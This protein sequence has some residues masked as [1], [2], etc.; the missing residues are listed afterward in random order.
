MQLF[1]SIKY[2]LLS[3]LLL[4]L[5]AC[6]EGSNSGFPT[7]ECG[8]ASNLCINSFVINPD[9]AAILLGGTQTYQAIATLTDGSERDITELVTWSVDDQEKAVIVV[10]GSSVIA[11]G[12]AEGSVNILANYRGIDV[13]A[14]LSVGAIT[15]TIS[16]IEASILTGM[17][18]SYKAFAIL[19]SG[20]QIDVTEQ[21]TWTSINPIIASLTADGAN[22]EVTGL[23]SGVDAISATYNGTSIFAQLTVISTTPESLLITPA[24]TTLPAGTSQQYNAYLTTTDN[25]VIDV[26]ASSTWTVVDAS[27]ASIDVNA[28]LTA[29]TIGDTQ[30]QASIVHE[31]ITL[32][33]TAA[34]SVNNAVLSS[35]VISPENGKFP[36]G[37][38]GVYR[39]A[40]YF[41][42]GSVI[43]VTREASWQV[44]D[45]TIG[46]IVGSG[47][48]AGDSIALSPG[49]TTISASLLS[50]SDSTNVEVSTA[51]IK[52]ISLSPQNATTPVGTAINY[53]A[54][55]FYSDG[56]KRDITQ[57]GAWSSSKPSVAAINFVG[58]QSGQATA[59]VVGTT[60]ITITFDGITKSTSLTVSDAIVTKLQISPLDPSV[61]VGIEGQFTAIAYYSD[62]TTADV[63]TTTNWLVDDYT[64]AAVIPTGEF[65][66]YAKALSQGTTQL[67]AS[68]QGQSSSTLITVSPAILESLSLSPTQVTIP[69]GT[70]QQYQL[71][72]VFSDGSNHDLTLFAS[73][74]SSKPIIASI[75]VTALASAHLIS[76]NSVAITAA[77][78]GIQTTASLSVAAGVLEYITLEPADQSIPVG[79]KAR[80][81][82]RAFY[83]GGINKDITDLATWS[84]DDGDIA[85]VD[86]TQADAGSV[87]GISEGIVTITATFEGE[88]AAGITTVTAAVL[89]S[90]TIT[91][92]SETIAA[93]LTQQYRLFA[94]FSDHTSREVTLVSDWQSAEP[95]AASIDSNGLATTYQEWQTMITGTYQGL[96]ASSNL[97]ITS[98]VASI[99]QITP[100][101]PSKPLG[102][103][104]NF[105][106]TVFYTDGYA[107]NVTESTTWTSNQSD[108]VQINASGPSAGLASADKIGISEITAS[109]SGLSA[110][111]NATVTSAE[112]TDIYI[113]PVNNAIDIGDKVSYNA[114]CKFS[115]GSLHNLPSNGIWQSSNTEVATIQ[116]T[117][118]TTAWATGID[119]GSVTITASVG[120]IVSNVAILKVAPKAVI[121]VVITSIQVTPATATVAVGAQDQFAAIAHYSDGSDADITSKATWLSD[122]SDVVNVTTT[123][124]NAGFAYSIAVGEANITAVMDNIASNS[125]KITVIGKTLD[126]IQIVPNNKSYNIGDTEQYKVTAI[127]DDYSIKDITAVSQIQSLDLTIATFDENNLMTAAGIGNA[128]LTA[129][130]QGMISERE[131]L[132]VFA[133]AP[134]PPILEVSP[135][136]IEVP[137]GTIDRYTATLHYADG[138]NKDV[139]SQALWFSNDT[140]IVNIM[141]NGEDAGFALATSAGTTSI[142]ASYKDINS[143]TAEVTVLATELLSV[144]IVIEDNAHFPE[145][146]TKHYTAFATYSDESV[147]EITRDATWKSDNAST[148][149]TVKGFVYGVNMGETNINIS[150]DGKSDSQ[151]VVVTDAVATSLTITPSYHEM[152]VHSTVDYTV[153]AILSD[154]TTENVT[155]DVLK[156]ATGTAELAIIYQEDSLVKVEGIT[157]GNAVVQANYQN[158][159]AT[160]NIVI[161]PATL[162]S[163]T[164]TPLN[165]TISLSSTLQ[166]QA[167]AQYSDGSE[168]NITEQA[169]WFSSELDIA[170][171]DNNTYIGLASAISTGTTTIQATFNGLSASTSLSVDASCGTH[172]PVS[173][174]IHPENTVIS[175]NTEMQYTLYGLWSNGCTTQLT[176]NNA[177]NWSSS[178]NKIVS[179]GK[180]DGIALAKKVGATTINADYQSLTAI[181]VNVT[182]TN[183]EVL[184]VS[185]Q[186]APS[187]ILS[188]GS[189][190]NYLCSARTAIDGIEQAEKFITG[191]ASFSSN[192][193][194]LAVIADNDGST[195]TVTAQNKAGSTTI[196]C[197]YGGKESSSSL[198]VQ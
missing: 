5:T 99:L 69:V 30:V 131:F 151:A 2:V 96:S 97:T 19:P 156:S 192:D 135:A 109:F 52:A 63:T 22:V 46:S 95:K 68:Y 58:A 74:Q 26:T 36:V 14:Q 81:E 66:G 138:T 150:F 185:I 78:N 9:K 164:I 143:N 141:P 67:T 121:P 77:Y 149:V 44:A 122:N 194:S 142:N 177:A 111:T 108:V 33:N 124:D 98:A 94:I 24:S 40:A 161:L 112:L 27:I 178:D 191:L 148:V 8:N 139:T 152:A 83:T 146:T 144:E 76:T 75:D 70:T 187:A 84:V 20:V 134:T 11:T 7:A 147:V 198:T 53:Q 61:P 189:S 188:K 60:D 51:E 105:V 72:G 155:K 89:E 118:P 184:S 91:P 6:G 197:S 186:P 196:T 37:K 13:T 171:I 100:P 56:S 1:N 62:N 168:V 114:I 49:K 128:E 195:Q 163:I 23:T 48:F 21:A 35:L 166:Y 190:L 41:S 179:I 159:S 133:P 132:H 169:N 127:Y 126:N 28:W 59:F 130:Y 80:L 174:Y 50:V 55:A 15:F 158:L 176:Q 181:P 90:V 103:I 153:V 101:N 39:A 157:S 65:S 64:V 43:D 71:F 85:S 137:Q 172:K 115:D 32:S 3:S 12:L 10:D 31:G 117:G 45:E 57:F 116:I 73:Y 154:G 16:P 92:I 34:L 107:A 113:N 102:T 42:D 175:V 129:V 88:Q 136:N 4:L 38:I 93:G 86:N 79:H 173:I 82:A 180:K 119:G 47:I 182:V 160:A 183:E 145:G 120:D 110:T 162:D 170:A 29:N 165:E 104:G 106:A 17:V 193:I 125:A 167:K 25:A 123:G 87:L 140:N 54:F 18:Q